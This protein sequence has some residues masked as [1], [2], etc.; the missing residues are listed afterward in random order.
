MFAYNA[1]EAMAAPE[2]VTTPIIT[3]VD[4]CEE[5]AAFACTP[6]PP[7]REVSCPTYHERAIE[8]A[9]ETERL[10]AYVEGAEVVLR[11]YHDYTRLNPKK[12]TDDFFESCRFDLMLI[13]IEHMARAV[14]DSYWHQACED[15]FRVW[16]TPPKEY[17]LYP[18][19]FPEYCQ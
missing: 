9:G 8:S 4:A 19:D 17:G 2:R 14:D 12:S 11:G 5:Q 18:E 6:P 13:G 15:L 10:N 16:P 3:T 1:G 7:P